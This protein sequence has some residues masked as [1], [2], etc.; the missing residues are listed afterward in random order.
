M[1][2]RRTPDTT[3]P[4]AA[5]Y[6]LESNPPPAQRAKTKGR[7]RPNSPIAR[8]QKA[9][10][11]TEDEN[12]SLQHATNRIALYLSPAKIHQNQV[13]GLAFRVLDILLDERVGNPDEVKDWSS[14]VEALLGEAE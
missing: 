1:S 3:Y 12:K 11:F 13:A 2:H 5:L 8:K 4:W 10:T 14:L 9:L 7:G 6:Q